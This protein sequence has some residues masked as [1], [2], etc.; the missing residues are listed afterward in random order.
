[1]AFALGIDTGGTFTDSV[2]YNL[3]E[4]T[5]VAKAKAPTTYHD[6]S[7]G[8]RNSIDNLA[9]KEFHKIKMG[10]LST[11][12]ATNAVVEG[13]GCE[14]GL[15]L[16]G[17]MPNGPLPVTHA[18]VVRGGHDLKGNSRDVL[19]LD[20]VAEALAVM[21]DKVEALAVSGFGSVRNPEHELQA[22]EFIERN[23]GL[24]APADNFAG[25]S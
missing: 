20:E 15:I 4:G 25:F 3:L 13:Q 2:V 12:M 22:K 17:E 18:A 8:I 19:A 9:F 11:T 14:V 21:K 24:P 7:C 10:S 23:C 5:V 6:L 1:M 16:I